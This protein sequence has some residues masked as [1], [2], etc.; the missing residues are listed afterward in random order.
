[1]SIADKLIRIKV[2]GK[3]LDY[4]I[5]TDTNAVQSKWDRMFGKAFEDEAG[6]EAFYA[7][8]SIKNRGS[9]YGKI[10]LPASSAFFT[11]L[12]IHE[13]TH[14]AVFQAKIMGAEYLD[15][16]AEELIATLTGQLCGVA[17][18]KLLP[19]IQ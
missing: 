5:L 15:T 12:V 9:S 7:E 10:Y 16:T 17:I 18:P 19:A 6:V 2:N 14:A 4:H 3:T 1:M 8:P 11:E 13:T